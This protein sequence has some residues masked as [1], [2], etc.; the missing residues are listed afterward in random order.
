MA[1]KC[2]TCF[3]DHRAN[4]EARILKGDS[5]AQIA[6]WLQTL[7]EHISIPSLTRHKN[8]CFATTMKEHKD[9][10]MWRGEKNNPPVDPN[11][12]PPPMI[13]VNRVMNTINFNDVDVNTNAIVESKKTQVL[14]EKILQ[15]QLIIVADLQQKYIDGTGGFPDAQIR[16]LKTIIDMINTLPAYTDKNHHLRHKINRFDDDETRHD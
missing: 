10:G 2:K 11:Y 6:A 8:N 12:I 5:M 3:S 16:C 15:T 13:D 1:G 14:A 7:N 9:A 4:I